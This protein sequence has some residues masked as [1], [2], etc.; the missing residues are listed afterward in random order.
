MST[1]VRVL[2]LV[3]VTI[4]L[5]ACDN[6]NQSIPD[7]QEMIAQLP[8]DAAVEVIAVTLSDVS[9]VNVKEKDEAVREELETSLAH[10]LREKIK[11]DVKS[12]HKN[13][14]MADTY[15]KGQAK[16]R[17]AGQVIGFYPLSEDTEILKEAE[18]LSLM[19]TDMI[20]RLDSL[21]RQRYNH[22]A[23]TQLEDTLRDLR[24]SG[25]DAAIKLFAV[26]EPSLLES[27]VA[28]LYVYATDEITKKLPSNEKS[29]LAKKA[30]SAQVDRRGLENF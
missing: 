21:R 8:D 14:L 28:S 30:T 5:L 17:E 26:I 2:V 23:A 9:A 29:T 18:V 25:T 13:A 27:S 19:Q 4:L 7:I 16:L 10:K 12:L 15:I 6:S 24:E 1:S 22:W 3:A 11:R 20:R